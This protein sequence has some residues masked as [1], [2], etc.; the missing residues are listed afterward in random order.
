MNG[1]TLALPCVD[2]EAIDGVPPAELLQTTAARRRYCQAV[3]LALVGEPSWVVSTW[4]WGECPAFLRARA[5]EEDWPTT[6]SGREGVSLTIMLRPVP[7]PESADEMIDA[8]SDQVPEALRELSRQ[9]L[10]ALWRG[11]HPGVDPAPLAEVFGGAIL[12]AARRGHAARKA[13]VEAAASTPE[14]V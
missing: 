3:A 2:F 5:A 1:A 7:L 8:A 13:A 12:Q 14:T 9:V 4:P 11:E 6:H 10:Q